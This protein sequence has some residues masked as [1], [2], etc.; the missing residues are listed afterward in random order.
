MENTWKNNNS[1][2][3]S[4]YDR[5]TNNYKKKKKKSLIIFCNAQMQMPGAPLKD[6]IFVSQKNTSRTSHLSLFLEIVLI[7]V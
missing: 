1:D 5:G 2:N 6:Q 7:L 4:N 3:Q